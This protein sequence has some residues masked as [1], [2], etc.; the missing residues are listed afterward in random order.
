ME[1]LCP[2]YWIM[3][4]KTDQG[5]SDQP[6][7]SS[8]E[9]DDADAAAGAAQQEPTTALTSRMNAATK[10][11]HD[12]S[13]HLVNAKL[14]VAFTDRRLY[15]TALA[16]FYVV[17][18]RL[19]ELVRRR[20]DEGN[21][22]R[23]DEESLFWP[24]MEEHVTTLLSSRIQGFEDD[25]AFYFDGEAGSQKAVAAARAVPAVADYVAHLEGLDEDNPALLLP[26]VFHLSLAILA[27]GQMIKRMARRSM[28]LPAGADG[29]T[30]M[31]THTLHFDS[32][33]AGGKTRNTVKKAFKTAVNRAAAKMPPDVLERMT[34]ESVGVFRRNNKMVAAMDMRKPWWRN[35][36]LAAALAVATPIFVAI[37]TR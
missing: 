16:S 14:L 18:K 24:S 15:G 28:S 33:Q 36:V 4:K 6:L 25:L 34:E 5:D 20:I 2:Y 7:E 1:A 19:D 26:Y 13:D 23:D 27:G 17:Y 10:D 35:R 37:A 30:T 22:A 11:I 32:A 29:K 31:G 3:P 9:P 12:L 21:K 8:A